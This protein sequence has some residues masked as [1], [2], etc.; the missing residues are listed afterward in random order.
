MKRIAVIANYDKPEVRDVLGALR[1]WAAGKNAE[2]VT[3]EGRPAATTGNAEELDAL[4]GMFGGCE[5]GVTLGGDGTLLYTAR[6]LAPLEIPILAVNLGSLG[7]H[8]QVGPGQLVEALEAVAAG[9]H[10]IQ[11]RVMLHV[12][13]EREGKKSAPVFALND[14][15]VARA[16]WGRMVHLRLSVN[17]HAATDL[18]ADGFVISTPTG[19]SAYN[20]AAGGPILTPSLEAFVMNAIC[21]HRMNFSPVVISSSSV[22]TIEFHPVKA[23][24][25]A[26]LIVDG[27]HWCG[28]S[29]GQTLNISRAPM[30]LPLIVFEDD[31]FEK[32][33]EKL[34]WGGLH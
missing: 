30:Y 10:R 7:F 34:A 25:E 17:G 11:P 2:V 18:F 1:S 9:R 22:I 21:P 3:D 13:I 23:A 26:H 20:Y 4:R 16:V 24:E 32:L 33:R 31:F 28:V 29:H 12:W 5:L 27:W 8:M 6:V 14:V 19:S 15:V